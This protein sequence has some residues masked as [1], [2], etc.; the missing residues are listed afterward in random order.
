MRQGLSTSPVEKRLCPVWAEPF[1]WHKYPPAALYWTTGGGV[2][3]EGLTTE[4][5]V[6]LA[7]LAS[8]QYARGHSAEDIELL[9]AFFDVVANNLALLALTAPGGESAG[10]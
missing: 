5:M 8:A 4:N 1:F 2:M 9:S 3:L 10:E 7:A 6:Y